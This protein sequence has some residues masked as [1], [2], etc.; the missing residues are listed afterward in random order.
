MHLQG[1]NE[2]N[3]FHAHNTE[4]TNNYAHNPI[5]SHDVAASNALL[6]LFWRSLSFTWNR[7]LVGFEMLWK[8]VEFRQT[9]H[10][11]QL[12]NSRIALLGFVSDLAE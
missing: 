6:V 10:V 2:A 4:P 1:F 12:S 3:R 11:V 7:L 8:S 5:A 9:N